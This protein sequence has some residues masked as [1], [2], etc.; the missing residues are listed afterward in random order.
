MRERVPGEIGR[1]PGRLHQRQLQR[2]ARVAA[3][4]H[5]ADR[6]AEQVAEPEHGRLGQLVRLLQQT[7]A[8]LLGHRQRLGHLV[9]LLHEHQVAQVLEQVADQAAQIL[10]LAGQLFDEDERLGGVRG[11]DEVEQ[12][13][14]GILLDRAQQLQVPPGR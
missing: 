12:A 11:D 4:A 1:R 3:G 14:E 13:E 9:H 6:L 10:P 7:P 2:Q 5:V 8:R